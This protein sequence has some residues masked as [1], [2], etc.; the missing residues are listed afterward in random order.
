MDWADTCLNTFW[1]VIDHSLIF[2]F[3]KW[4]IATTGDKRHY[5]KHKT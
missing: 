4:I 2:K 3:A 5:K 1:H